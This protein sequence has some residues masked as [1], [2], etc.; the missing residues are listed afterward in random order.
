MVANSRHPW[1]RTAVELLQFALETAKS[2]SPIHQTVAFLLLDVCV[3]TTMR[4]F[5]SLPEGLL[6]SDLTYFDRRKHSEGNFHALTTGIQRSAKNKMNDVDLHHATYYHNIRNQLY[7]RGKG[8]TADP[9]DVRGYSAVAASLLRNLLDLDAVEI[10]DVT[11]KKTP[12]V[13]Q[14]SFLLLKKDLP[15]DLARFRALI[16]E[17]IETLE[18]QLIYPTT[19]AKLSDLS[20]NIEVSSFPQKLNDLRDLIE[21]CIRDDEIRSWFLDLVSGDIYGDGKQALEN[22][23]FLMGLGKDHISLYS[24]VI[25]LFFL[26]LGDVRREDVDKYQDISFVA[27]PDY[28]IMGVYESCCFWKEYLAMKDMIVAEDHSALERALE[29]HE[30]L[31]ATIRRLEGLL[32]V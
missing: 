24:L 19:I 7:H 29:V 28:S 4:I 15:R 23:H 14:H 13:S 2:S 3:E 31:Q 1:Q 11:L 27:D 8:L 20:A 6:V 25:G 10:P 18:P 30:R 16:N 5:L 32:P 22:A 26:P 9:E 21:K 12:A 17:L